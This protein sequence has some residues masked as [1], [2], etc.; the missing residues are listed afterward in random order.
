MDTD[1]I[2]RAARHPAGWA[3]GL[4]AIGAL[5]LAAATP[6][7][8][9]RTALVLRLGQPVRVIN[10]G[11]AAS[12]QTGL[13]LRVPLLDQVV[14]LDRRLLTLTVENIAVGTVDGQGITVDAFAT[15][16][17]TDP[18]RFYAALGTPDQANVALRAIFAA[19]VQ[20]QL[21]H[22]SVADAQSLARDTGSA[23][24]RTAFDRELG[25]YG[26]T[27]TDVRLSRV[28]LADGAPLDDALARLSATAQADAA[29]IA[30]DGH[31]NAALIRAAAEARAVQIYAASF[32]KDPQFH[33]FY[34]AMQS[35]DTSL[36]QKGSR[37][38]IVLSPDN[39]Y[40]R[41]FRGK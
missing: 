32:G 34:R 3:L 2:V 4:A 1:V 15:W 7:P 38:T 33:E 17:V 31:R 11:D 6:V 24:L 23:A 14:W 41:Q 9:D 21:G 18:A 37:T 10:G 36:A 12:G 35:Y 19:A 8:P 29:A 5:A 20:Q 28:V 13:A 22:G 30:E 27:V 16:R 26:A 25:N 39:A 40:L